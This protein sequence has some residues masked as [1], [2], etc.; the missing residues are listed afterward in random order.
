MDK[1]AMRRQGFLYTWASR[2]DVDMLS[3]LQRLP[4]RLRGL[5]ERREL[6]QWGPGW[7]PG[8]QCTFGIFE[9]HKTAHK[10]LSFS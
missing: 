6:P 4:N 10:T 3:V 2:V 5:E 9:A 7:S 8:R 1:G